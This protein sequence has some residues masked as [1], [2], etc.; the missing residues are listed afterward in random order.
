[1]SVT[2]FDTDFAATQLLHDGRD[3]TTAAATD[4]ASGLFARIMQALGDAYTVKMPDGE[5]IAIFPPC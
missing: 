5:V 1:M 3:A 4:K 2:T